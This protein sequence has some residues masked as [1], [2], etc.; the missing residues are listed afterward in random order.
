[1]R[2]L[3]ENTFSAARLVSF[4]TRH[5]C[6]YLS[7][8]FV[9][10]CLKRRRE[11]ENI[12]LETAVAAEHGEGMAGKKKKCTAASAFILAGARRSRFF[13]ENKPLKLQTEKYFISFRGIFFFPL[14]YMF[15]S[16][17]CVLLKS[18]FLSVL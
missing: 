1:M 12:E 17:R 14:G 13:S 10:I 15:F 5:Y 2:V 16:N 9:S 18:V 4:D 8:D 7:N 6:Y 11:K 3:R